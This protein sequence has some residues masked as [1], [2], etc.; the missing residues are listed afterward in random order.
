MCTDNKKVFSFT[1]LFNIVFFY[2]IRQSNLRK[3]AMF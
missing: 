1:K 3:V 2:D